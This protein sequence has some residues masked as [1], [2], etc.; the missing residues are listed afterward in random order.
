MF[1][2]AEKYLEKIKYKRIKKKLFLEKKVILRKNVIFNKNTIFEGN[3][4]IES[5]TDIRNSFIGQGSYCRHDGELS[6]IKISKYCSI[7]PKVSI[8]KGKHPTKKIVS[9]H[10]FA[11]SSTPKEVGL[12]FIENEIFKSNKIIEKNYEVV[13]GNDVWI[14]ENVKILTGIKIGNGAIIGTGAVVVKDVPAYAIVGGVPA[15][16]IRYRFTEEEIKFLEEFKWW[17]R[18]LKW[19]EENIELFGDIKLFLDTIK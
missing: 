16:I 9:T 13:I 15:K 19:I 18:D 2:F 5:N 17:D 7:A 10:P 12:G 3:N 8:I 6:D 11:Y 14:G 1:R 4:I